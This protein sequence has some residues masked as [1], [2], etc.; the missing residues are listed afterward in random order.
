LHR[1]T[2]STFS[3][4]NKT[5]LVLMSVQYEGTFAIN[6]DTA[7]AGQASVVDA[8]SVPPQ[9][10][11]CTKLSEVQ[12]FLRINQSRC[13]HPAAAAA[14]AAA[15]DISAQQQHTNSRGGACVVAA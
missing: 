7:A 2:S 6:A 12:T 13:K 3:I 8:T 1:S 14:A 11:C 10:G 5:S 4:E 15:E 9:A